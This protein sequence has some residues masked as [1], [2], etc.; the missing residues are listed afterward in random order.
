MEELMTTKDVGK[1]LNVAPAKVRE[2]VD[3]GELRFLEIG[4]NMQRRTIRF[5]RDWVNKYID[6]NSQVAPGRKLFA[7]SRPKPEPRLV[8]KF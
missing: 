1:M 3:A 2:L 8:N 6:D 7:I 5:R 4:S